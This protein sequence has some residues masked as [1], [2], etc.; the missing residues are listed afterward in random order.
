MVNGCYSG[1][2]DRNSPRY[3]EVS[4][5][6]TWFCIGVEGRKRKQAKSMRE[7]AMEATDF[8]FYMQR[9]FCCCATLSL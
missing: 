3:K 4:S 8:L 9:S 1:R 7:R 5:T 6:E 2:I